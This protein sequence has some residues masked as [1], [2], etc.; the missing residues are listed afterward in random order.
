MR[1]SN[2]FQRSLKKQEGNSLVI[3]IFVIVVL[4]AL[5]AALSNLVRTTS[6]SVV[7]EV[8]G[9]RSFMAAQSGIEH[10]MLKLYPLNEE[11]VTECPDFTAPVAVG[12]CEATVT[13][14]SVDV[15]GEPYIHLRLM[16]VGFCNAG[17]QQA[18]R[19]IAVETRVKE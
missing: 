13:C 9:T 2:D 12:N 7:I 18:G 14:Q 10:G 1:H 19:Q 5:V 3:A 4:G 16:S 17:G 15:N 8:L 6:E 11:P